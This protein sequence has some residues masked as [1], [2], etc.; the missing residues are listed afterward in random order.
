MARHLAWSGHFRIKNVRLVTS[1]GSRERTNSTLKVLESKAT[2]IAI[3]IAT[4]RHSPR[5]PFFNRG[6]QRGGRSRGESPYLRE[7]VPETAI[8]Y[9]LISHNYRPSQTSRMPERLCDS[10]C[11]YAKKFLL[12]GPD[13]REKSWLSRRI[14][15]TPNYDSRDNKRQRKL[16]RSLFLLSSSRSLRFGRRCYYRFPFTSAS[17]Q[18]CPGTRYS[19]V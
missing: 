3:V 2:I 1:P 17:C 5:P 18:F 11:R 13:A 8:N 4:R 16:K 9:R 10:A 7:K 15:S 12:A 6:S 14:V 19:S